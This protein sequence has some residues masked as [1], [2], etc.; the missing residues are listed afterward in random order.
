MEGWI[1]LYR[2]FIDWEWYDDNNTK[3]VFIHCLL[4][5]NNEQKVWRGKTINRGQFFTS[6]K[7]LCDELKLTDKQVRIALNKLKKTKEI[8]TQGANN[9]RYE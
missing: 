5:A 6:I 2:K 9:G 8:A 4:K 3:S 7:S 1:S